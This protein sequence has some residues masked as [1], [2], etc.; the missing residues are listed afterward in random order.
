MMPKER[1]SLPCNLP[2]IWSSY[3]PY[4]HQYHSDHYR[5]RTPNINIKKKNKSIKKTKAL[6]QN[7]INKIKPN[8]LPIKSYILSIQFGSSDF[9][10][11]IRLV[12]CISIVIR[13]LSLLWYINKK[14]NT[15]LLLSWL[16]SF[17]GCHCK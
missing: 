10:G 7:N 16:Q 4:W 6:K 9:F 5:K 13:G 12:G 3:E 11:L 1:E 14:Y 2:T 15:F 8:H 17:H